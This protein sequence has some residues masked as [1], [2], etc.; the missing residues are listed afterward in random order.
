MVSQTN[1]SAAQHPEILIS[2]L[3]T[4]VGGIDSSINTRMHKKTHF[5]CLYLR[6]S[7][8]V[9][10]AHAVGRVITKF[11]PERPCRKIALN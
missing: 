3:K 7:G 2:G 11:Q 6:E 5:L 1:R 4:R 10:D 9:S 8:A